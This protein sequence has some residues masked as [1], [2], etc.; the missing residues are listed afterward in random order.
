ML[1]HR[2]PPAPPTGIYR[3]GIG[4]RKTANYYLQLADKVLL[5]HIANLSNC[6]SKGLIGIMHKTISS[7]QDPYFFHISID[8]PLPQ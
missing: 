1:S 5:I 2:W 6:L 3:R 8:V 4:V 7:F